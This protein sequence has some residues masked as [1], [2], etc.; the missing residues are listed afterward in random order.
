M[1]CLRS[2]P[3]MWEIHRFS[4][5]LHHAGRKQSSQYGFCLVTV[6]KNMKNEG[7]KMGREPQTWHCDSR[8]VKL[9][10]SPLTF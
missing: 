10:I 7:M 6:G 5:G 9:V 3:S 1:P 2:R 8:L 4:T